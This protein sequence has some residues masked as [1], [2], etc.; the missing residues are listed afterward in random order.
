MG[1]VSLAEGIE[2]CLPDHLHTGRYL[3]TGKGMALPQ[4]MLILTG[5]IDERRPTV[6]VETV[7]GGRSHMA[8]TVSR[9]GPGRAAYAKRGSY[10]VSGFAATLQHRRQVIEI[11][12]VSAPADGG[13]NGRGLSDGLRLAGLQRQRFC[14][15]EYLLA[16]GQCE[17]TDQLHS[18]RLGCIVPD[19][20]VDEHSVTRPVVPDV[21]AKR[22]HPH[23]VGRYQR[24]GT[25][26]S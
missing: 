8:G 19:F 26:Q 20:G 4:Q 7:V 2:A 23:L 14:Q 6:E 11:G 10:L 12:V 9:A 22:F 25:E 16:A 1:L 21:Y 17:L 24:N 5:A 13:L 3:L 18:L 15:T